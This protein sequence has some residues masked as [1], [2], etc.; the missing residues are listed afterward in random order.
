MISNIKANPKVLPEWAISQLET[1][2]SIT[3]RKGAYRGARRDRGNIKNWDPSQ[4]DADAD[5]LPDMQMNRARTRDLVRNNPFGAGAVGTNCTHIVGT[6]L[7]MH[8]RINSKLL[9]L[10]DDEA[11][12]WQSNTEAEFRSW[13]GSLDC[14]IN[15]GLN[16]YDYQKLVL[17]SVLESG[18]TFVL[19]PYREIKSLNYGTRL[20]IIEAD[21]VENPNGKVDSN[22]LSAGVIKNKSGTPTGYHIRTRHPGADANKQDERKWPVTMAFG[23]SGRRKIIHVF[24]KLRPGQTRGIPYLAPVIEILKQASRYTEATLQDAVISSYFS[25]FVES[26]AGMDFSPFVGDDGPTSTE[27]RS[28]KDYM[29]SS[30]GVIGMRPGEKVTFGDPSRPNQNFDAFMQSI[31]RQ[32]GVG[33][34]LPYEILIQHFQKSYSAARS[35]FLL[36]WKM[37]MTRRAWLVDHFCDLVYGAWMQEAI[38]RGRVVAPGFDEPLLKMAWL[39][40]EWVG[41]TQG[42][43]QPKDEVIAMQARVDGGFTTETDEVGALGGDYDNNLAQRRR[44]AKN[45]KEIREIEFAAEHLKNTGVQMPLANAGGEPPPEEDGDDDTEG[46]GK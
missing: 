5:S 45:R 8:A 34:G 11:S 17:R 1:S 43:I 22:I 9:G 44:E 6:G 2:G 37:F 15:R 31:I 21:R 12:E 4:G 23:P 36:A 18:D 41:P 40:N 3:A 13:T 33:L 25:V 24:E 35:S 16:F 27:Q 30:N 29:L 20:Q 14:D 19:L 42:Q 32:I 46:E 26:E 7:V 38:F 39:R 28:A 10:S